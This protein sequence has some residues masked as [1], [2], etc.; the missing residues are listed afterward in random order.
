MSEE[1]TQ[2]F[3]IAVSFAGEDREYVSDLVQGLKG[4]L[5]VFYD[6]DF[7][8]ETW[9]EDLVDYF[10]NLYQHRTRYVVMFI[11]RHYA[12]K[13]WTNLERRSALAQ[14]VTRRSAYVLPVRLDDTRLEGLLPT[15]GYIEAK[16]IGLPGLIDAVRAKVEHAPRTPTASSTVLDGKVP[17]TK[18]AVEA[19]ISE[20]GGIWEYLLFAGLLRQNMDALEPQYRDFVMGYAPR[21][22]RHV[23]LK[24]LIAYVQSMIGQIDAI[25]G[26]FSVVLDPDVQER[27][28]GAPGQPGDV[29]RIV[30]LAERFVAVYRDFMDWAAEVRGTST[31]VGSESETLRLL[32]QWAAQ[33]VESCR[34]FVEEFT[35]QMDSAT[36]RTDAGERLEIIMPVTLTLDP[37]VT[38]PFHASLRKDLGLGT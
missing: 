36:E 19:L 24:D 1:E 23:E 35:E 12:E 17:R 10:T 37:E 3:D 22:G 9:G 38:E 4:E 16:R 31:R 6:E 34:K 15:V 2:D 33:P 26:N 14:A 30:H 18:E 32:A 25:V 20:R 5:R 21:T 7:L 13:M 28:F 29:D 11:S 27:A 8:V